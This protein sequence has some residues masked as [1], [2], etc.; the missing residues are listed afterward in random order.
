MSKHADVK[1]Q[2]IREIPII[3]F[4]TI[5]TLLTEKLVSSIA[6]VFPHNKRLS[7]GNSL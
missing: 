6:T 2:E 3:V 5:N 4:M 1:S 7:V